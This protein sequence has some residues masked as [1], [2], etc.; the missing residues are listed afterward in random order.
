MEFIQRGRLYYEDIHKEEVFFIMR[1]NTNK[2]V[3]FTGIN[4]ESRRRP[5]IKVDVQ[6]KRTKKE[7]VWI[8]TLFSW[9]L[10]L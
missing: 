10:T 4:R 9:Q 8:L 6:N 1:K 2:V 7:A 3:D 5:R